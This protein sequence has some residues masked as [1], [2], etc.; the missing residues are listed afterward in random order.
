MRRGAV[1]LAVLVVLMAPVLLVA[2]ATA[3]AAL[4]LAGEPC[5]RRA[6]FERVQVV[7]RAKAGRAH[8]SRPH[9]W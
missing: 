9:G 3:L 8:E 4:H 6:R 5:V 7:R 2:L 1:V